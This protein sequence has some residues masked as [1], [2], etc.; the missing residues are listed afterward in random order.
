MTAD[1]ILSEPPS[2]VSNSGIPF[3]FE[4]YL[5]DAGAEQIEHPL[6]STYEGKTEIKRYRLGMFYFET[7]VLLSIPTGTLIIC[8]GFGENNLIVHS[9]GCIP[10]NREEADALFLKL[11][12]TPANFN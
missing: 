9:D 4:K 8:D 10:E 12:I 2:T 11:G 1:L 6:N 5:F 3:C 7:S